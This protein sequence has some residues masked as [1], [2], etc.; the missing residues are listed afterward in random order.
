MIF[1]L[2]K[3][4]LF[5]IRYEVNPLSKKLL[6]SSFVVSS[7]TMVSR[8]L[9]FAR[10]V[11][12]A[13]VFG[14]SPAMDAFLIAFKIPNF[15]RRL[16]AEGAFNQAFVPVLS[17]YKT[18]RDEAELHSLIDRVTGSLGIILFV[19][20]LLGVVGA[21]FVIM[22]F[23]PGAYLNDQPK[24]LLATDLLVLTF[25]YLFFISL[26]ALAGG[27]LNTMGKF[28]V[29][30]FTPVL[31]NI[32]M[33]SAALWLA[34]MMDEPVM[35][36]AWGV[37]F[38]GIVQLLFQIPFL[39]RIGC[40][41]RPKIDF[42]HE[43][44]K[45]IKTLI[46]PA[47]FGVSVSQINLLL[48]LVL[49]SFLVS[50]SISWLYYS[51]RLM[52]FPLGIFG[53]ALATVILPS[54]SKT[55]ASK[56]DGAFSDTIDW[57]LRLAVVIGIPAA[58][59][60]VV[61]AGPMIST[62]FQSDV[63]TANDVL[64]SS[65]SLMAYGVGLSGFIFIKVLAPGFFARQDTMTPVKIGVISMFANMVLNLIFVYVFHLQHTGLA[66]ATSC[67]AFLNAVLLYRQLRKDEVYR[68]KRGWQK[69]FIQVLVANMLMAVLLVWGVGDLASW[70]N[71]GV[72]DKALRLLGLILAG[73]AVY[74]LSLILTGLN[75]KALLLGKMT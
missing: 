57:A 2:F 53:V 8:V 17:E 54:L 65:Y 33:I 72:F 59:G 73:M 18:E 7:M 30:A 45:R 55:H 19:I 38:A 4:R 60:L 56:N 27:I 34:P 69:L 50:G 70:T 63:Y 37:F 14:A 1:L 31:L 58:V 29:A 12:Y 39:K 67:A 9:G 40:L 51:D 11:M 5:Q 26:T 62:L 36:L 74:L 6:K 41:P 22:L 23:A 28:S 46:I 47:L 49:A 75:L 13:R 16:F 10:D 25:P 68:P 24:Y 35:G 66:L 48:D 3:G 71:S 32:C 20:T 52:E 42:Q 15:L 64:L 43:G 61:L 44:V 21:P